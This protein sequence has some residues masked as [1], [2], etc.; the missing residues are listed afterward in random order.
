MVLGAYQW[1][2]C[3]SGTWL[4]SIALIKWKKKKVSLRQKETP[5]QSKANKQ[6][7]EQR[8]MEKK[9]QEGGMKAKRQNNAKSSERIISHLLLGHSTAQAWP[10]VVEE[11]K[12]SNGL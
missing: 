12:L 3:A 9:E 10:L 1:Q 8:M 4:I 6:A 7:S 2:I 11:T 5:T